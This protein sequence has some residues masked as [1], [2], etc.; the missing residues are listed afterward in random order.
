MNNDFEKSFL[1]KIKGNQAATDVATSGDKAAAKRAMGVIAP[2]II[3]CTIAWTFG[4]VYFMNM[5]FVKVRPSRGAAT[6]GETGEE[7]TPPT[8][9]S[10]E[11]K[12]SIRMACEDGKYRYDFYQDNSYELAYVGQPYNLE[13]GTYSIDGSKIILTNNKGNTET[14]A[15]YAENVLSVEDGTFKC[16]EIGNA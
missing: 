8:E 4:A 5:I 1:D 6:T 15:S 11:D 7:E 9:P 2:I 13:E 14:E 16:K 12:A 3:I 10:V